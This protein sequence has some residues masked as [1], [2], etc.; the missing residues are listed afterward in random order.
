ME[1]VNI[2]F[3]EV[4]C[5]HQLLPSTSHFSTESEA[6][7][8]TNRH[9]ESLFRVPAICVVGLPRNVQCCYVRRR[10]SHC[11]ECQEISELFVAP[12][13]S[14]FLL[15]IHLP[16][17]LHTQFCTAHFISGSPFAPLWKHYVDCIKLAVSVTRRGCAFIYPCLT[18]Y[19]P[20]DHF[21]DQIQAERRALRRHVIIS[22]PHTFVRER[23]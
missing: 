21:L 23:L 6:G 10:R 15:W 14:P 13:A 18:I 16:G 8:R 1:R 19:K 7:L 17:C 5:A 12:I 9:A 2:C 20:F 4:S 11:D 3:C 22:P